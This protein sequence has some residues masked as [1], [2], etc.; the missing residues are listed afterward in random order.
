MDREPIDSPVI[1]LRGIARALGCD[2]GRIETKLGEIYGEPVPVAATAEKRLDV[3]RR[4]LGTGEAESVLDR[5]MAVGRQW[6]ES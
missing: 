1:V 6:R 2:P 5:A 3:I 4:R